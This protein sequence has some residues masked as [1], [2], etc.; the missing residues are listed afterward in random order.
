[1]K[2]LLASRNEGKIK[3]FRE[4][5]N[6][7]GIELISLID[8][9]EDEEVAETGQTFRENAYLKAKFYC[10]K[11]KMPTF[12]D[13]SGLVVDALSGKPGVMSA[14]F[15][16]KKSNN[17]K[18]NLK[19]LKK[20][21]NKQNRDARFV[22]VICYIDENQEFTFFNGVLEGKILDSMQGENGFGY[23]PLFY[24]P[25]YEMT[26]AQMQPD[27]KTFLSHRYDATEKLIKYL[28]KGHKNV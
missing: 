20:M 11:Y 6:G 25:A 17:L 9:N 23:D 10:D 24:I 14:R 8:L 2:V 26:L 27:Q 4:M 19:L 1:M 12:A 13:D 5:F 7:T 18:N 28:Q 16:G 3:E 22:C 21:K 15:S